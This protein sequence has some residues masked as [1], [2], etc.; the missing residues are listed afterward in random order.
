MVHEN[1]LPARAQLEDDLKVLRNEVLRSGD[2]G[3]QLPVNLKRLIWNAQ[4]MFHC[5]P[6]RRGPSGNSHPNNNLLHWCLHINLCLRQVAGSERYLSHH[7]CMVCLETTLY[8]KPS[9]WTLAE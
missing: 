9:W 2:A 7:S 1:R 8:S 4:N 3:V 5:Q 6:H